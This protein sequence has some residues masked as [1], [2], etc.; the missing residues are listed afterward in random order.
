MNEW[1]KIIIL[2]SVH[3]SR[4]PYSSA[5]LII[6]IN[7]FM[8]SSHHTSSISRNLRRVKKLSILTIARRITSQDTKQVEFIGCKS[9]CF[10]EE[11]ALGSDEWLVINDE[12][13]NIHIVSIIINI[14]VIIIIVIVI[15]IVILNIPLHDQ[16]ME[17]G[18]VQYRKYLSSSVLSRNYS[19]H[20]STP[21]A[22]REEPR[23]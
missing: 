11:T 15:V 5:Y 20:N 19:P 3:L 10:I 4:V 13:K 1:M 2:S 6:H 8:A 23:L 17:C 22:I 12:N 18:R 21:M 14:I 7:Q 9:T 16:Q